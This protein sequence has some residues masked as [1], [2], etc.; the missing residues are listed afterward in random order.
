MSK[1]TCSFSNDFLK[2]WEI[3]R[4]TL[5]ESFLVKSHHRKSFLDKQANDD[6]NGR[7]WKSKMEINI[8]QNDKPNYSYIIPKWSM[9]MMSRLR[10]FLSAQTTTASDPLW[11]HIWWSFLAA[12][13]I[14]PSSEEGSPNWQGRKSCWSLNSMKRVSHAACEFLMA[15]HKKRFNRIDEKL[16]TRDQ[17]VQDC[18]TKK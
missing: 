16:H 6:R 3:F 9:D 4:A 13:E 2:K 15:P 1:S 14:L 11:I 5:I 8:S 7:I 12:A 18:R 10:L 17:Q